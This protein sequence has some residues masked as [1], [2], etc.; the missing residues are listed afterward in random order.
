MRSLQECNHHGQMVN[1][2]VLTA[3]PKK[4]FFPETVQRLTP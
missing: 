4:M 3:F 2:L 1:L